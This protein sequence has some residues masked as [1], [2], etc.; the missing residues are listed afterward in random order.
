ML[1]SITV[2]MKALGEEKGDHLILLNVF[3]LIWFGLIVLMFF[4]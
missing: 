4:G 2:V 1:L 3:E